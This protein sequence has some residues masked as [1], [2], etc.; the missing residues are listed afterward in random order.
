M[1]TRRKLKA[2][3]NYDV[4]I[5]NVKTIQSILKSQSNDNYSEKHK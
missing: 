4:I 1:Q 5:I 2:H 3:L